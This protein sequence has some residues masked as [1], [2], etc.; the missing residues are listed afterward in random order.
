[1]FVSATTQTSLINSGTIINDAAKT[2]VWL[3]LLNIN[4]GPGLRT[5]LNPSERIKGRTRTEISDNNRALK[6]KTLSHRCIKDVFDHKDTSKDLSSV[7]FSVWFMDVTTR[8][9][10][11][12]KNFNIHSL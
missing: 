9:Q 6:P 12:V 7:I 2:V 10:P 8:S 11:K 3:F 1:M 4:E 5:V